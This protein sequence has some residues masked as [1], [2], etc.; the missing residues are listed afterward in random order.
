LAVEKVL[1]R[2]PRIR[3]ELRQM[4]N[5]TKDL[6]NV[7]FGPRKATVKNILSKSQHQNWLIL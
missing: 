5:L 1:Q 7:Q 2:S 4:Q 6:N 3:K